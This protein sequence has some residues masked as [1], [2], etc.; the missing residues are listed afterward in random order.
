MQLKAPQQLSG[1]QIPS[2]ISLQGSSRQNLPFQLK[3][4]SGQEGGNR[5]GRL[6]DP[7]SLGSGNV[8]FSVFLGV[9]RNTG[10]SLSAIS[11]WGNKCTVRNYLPSSTEEVPRHE[12]IKGSR[13]FTLQIPNEGTPTS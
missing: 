8:A 11:P 6:E 12:L 1:S 9:V 7:E 13:Y 5:D 3:A 2:H 4:N 10:S